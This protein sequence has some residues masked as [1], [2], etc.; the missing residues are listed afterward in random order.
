MLAWAGD[1]LVAPATTPTYFSPHQKKAETHHRPFLAGS[2]PYWLVRKYSPKAFFLMCYPTIALWLKLGACRCFGV[3]CGRWGL[4]AW[5]PEGHWLFW[6][7]SSFPPFCSNLRLVVVLLAAPAW[8]RS[9]DGGGVGL[10]LV[11]THLMSWWG[12]FLHPWGNKIAKSGIEAVRLNYGRGAGNLVVPQ[13]VGRSPL[14]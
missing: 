4:P 5:V 2:S 7:G 8:F 1:C 12:F 10:I 6:C 3:R 9:P 11:G 13:T 14:G